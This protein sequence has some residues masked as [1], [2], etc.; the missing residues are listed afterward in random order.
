M[1]QPQ[2]QKILVIEDNEDIQQIIDLA[3]VVVGGFSIVICGSGNEG[4]K[5]ALSF[6]PQLILIDVMMPEM[7][8]PTT[9]K[10]LRNTPELAHIPIIFTTAKVQPSEVEEYIKLGAI[11]VISKPFDPIVLPSQILQIWNKQK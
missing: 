3:L 9:L 6:N 1:P 7:D 5:K 11:G 2:L 10:M 8:G 4:L